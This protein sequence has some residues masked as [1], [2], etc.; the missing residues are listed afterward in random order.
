MRI[1]NYVAQM[2]QEEYDAL[3]PSPDEYR[4]GA[5]WLAP[6][7]RGPGLAL[8]ILE[9]EEAPCRA[10]GCNCFVGDLMTHVY[11]IEICKN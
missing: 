1:E 6:C 9:G 11:Q 2:T 3:P 4:K 7:F 8:H 5:M 10:Y